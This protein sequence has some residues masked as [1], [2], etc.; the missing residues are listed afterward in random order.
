MK[1]FSLCPYLDGSVHVG[2]FN[3][4][5]NLPSNSYAIEEVVDK[6]DVVYEGVNVTG[7]QHQQSGDQLN[8]GREK[9]VF[10]S[11]HGENKGHPKDNM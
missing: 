2:F 5:H 10:I 3:A 4:Q 8:E 6:T 1:T 11:G 9:V 7:A